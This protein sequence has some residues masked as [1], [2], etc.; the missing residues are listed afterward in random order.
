M[1]FFE[2]ELAKV[3]GEGD[4]IERPEFAGGCCVGSLGNDLRV[5]TQF[6]TCGVADQY[7]ALRL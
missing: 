2:Q 6:V 1:N 3:F 4:V 5:K 7:E